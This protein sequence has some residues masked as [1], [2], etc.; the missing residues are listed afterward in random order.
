MALSIAVLLVP[1][2]LVVAFCQATG[3]ERAPTVDPGPVWTAARDADR[4]AV[5]VPQGL[6]DG[7]RVTRAVA[8]RGDGGAL[9][10]RVSYE[11][12]AGEFAQLVESDLDAAGLLADELGG[13][14]AAGG[15]VEVAG[16]PWQR[17]PGR[18]DGETALVLLGGGATYLVTGSAGVDELRTLAAA[19]R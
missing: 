11:T 9:T 12:P 5:R 1:I 16:T 14:R 3:A 8:P 18:R 19:L 6:P 4:F 7:W 15:T 13:P 17:Y 2:L 10:V